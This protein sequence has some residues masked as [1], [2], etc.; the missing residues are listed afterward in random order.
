MA[1]SIH[2]LSED[3]IGDLS[4]E[5]K[6][7][8]KEFKDIKNNDSTSDNFELSS[9]LAST[10]E[11]KETGENSTTISK[12][13]PQKESKN[14]SKK[15]YN[16]VEELKSLDTESLEY[17]ETYNIEDIIRNDETL[18]ELKKL[19]SILEN[20]T[21]ES[22][23]NENELALTSTSRTSLNLKDET[24]KSKI[25][26]VDST[27]VRATEESDSDRYKMV[28]SDSSTKTAK[29]KT[30]IKKNITNRNLENLTF[31]SKS[32]RNN[33]L[34]PLS[35][36]QA[37]NVVKNG[38]LERRKISKKEPQKIHSLQIVKKSY[39]EGSP[40]YI[41]GHY[42]P[43]ILKKKKVLSDVERKG[44]K[45]SSITEEPEVLS[46]FPLKIDCL[47]MFSDDEVVEEG[48]EEESST[49]SSSDLGEPEVMFN[50]L[51]QDLLLPSDESDMD[52]EEFYKQF[53][54]LRK[55]TDNQ[56]S[57]EESNENYFYQFS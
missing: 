34:K 27:I 50:Q 11:S 26:S 8:L 7:L 52:L 40:D 23:P 10:E 38:D 39:C 2:D 25:F 28:R 20:N 29:G 47:S 24:E 18:K 55:K 22:E 14:R 41:K 21:N 15:I 35:K 9:W 36:Q 5:I 4:K 17:S 33:S 32:K 12:D 46:V 57:E 43:L 44:S 54:K 45:Q 30:T 16:P 31:D 37:E 1:K 42:V 48:V 51:W 6:E 13:I 56:E 49:D 53:P 3:E 19:T